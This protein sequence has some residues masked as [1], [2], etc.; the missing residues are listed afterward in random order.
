MWDHR[1]ETQVRVKQMSTGQHHSPVEHE[2]KDCIGENISIGDLV[3]V[4]SVPDL[5]QLSA[6]IRKESGPAFRHCPNFRGPLS[7]IHAEMPHIAS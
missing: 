4:A 6:R 3:R 7:N 5:S 1:A 2:K